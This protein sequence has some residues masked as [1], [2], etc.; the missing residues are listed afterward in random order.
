MKKR[1]EN[2]DVFLLK[3]HKAKAPG[4]RIEVSYFNPGQETHLPV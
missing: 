1:E 3:T 4:H 2:Q